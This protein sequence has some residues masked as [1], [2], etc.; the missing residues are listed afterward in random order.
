MVSRVRTRHTRTVPA[1]SIVYLRTVAQRQGVSSKKQLC[2]LSRCPE[3]VC[4]HCRSNTVVTQLTQVGS[5]MSVLGAGIVALRL[6]LSRSS[7][8]ATLSQRPRY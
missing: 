2:W 7:S 4:S 5:E 1:V 8:T 3:G 6:L